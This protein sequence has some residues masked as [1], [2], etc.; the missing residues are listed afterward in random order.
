MA[1]ESYKI[2]IRIVKLTRAACL[3]KNL[4]TAYPNE[5]NYVKATS[6]FEIIIESGS[7]G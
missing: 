2:V 6:E 5:V 1:W 4:N 7:V 3:T